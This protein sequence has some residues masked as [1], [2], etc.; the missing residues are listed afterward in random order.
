VGLGGETVTQLTLDDVLARRARDDALARVGGGAGSWMGE[1][2]ALAGH[3]LPPG[4]E[5]TGEDL[6]LALTEAGLRAP[7]HHNAW[8][9]L[10]LGLVA[11][12]LLARTGQMR[13][14]RTA[15]S[16][17]RRTAVYRRVCG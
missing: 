14:M 15:R 9:A 13:G 17:A 3:L 6:R 16:H 11:R 8:G 2:R 10:V 1:A 4:W 12:G 7:H 5:G